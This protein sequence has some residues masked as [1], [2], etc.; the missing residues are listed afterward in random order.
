M[1]PVTL[2]TAV[3]ALIDYHGKILLLRES[4]AY[5]DGVQEGLYDFPGGRIDPGEAWNDALRR[6]VREECGLEITIGRPFHVN[7]VRID[8]TDTQWQIIRMFFICTAPNDQVILSQ[9]HDHSVWSTPDDLLSQNL[10]PN[11]IDVAQAY[12]S[13]K[14][15]S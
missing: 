7:E 11:L 8:R 6:E 15:Q 5:E 13:Y 9:D 1:P 12:I 4:P 10:M 2:F 14:G 3:K